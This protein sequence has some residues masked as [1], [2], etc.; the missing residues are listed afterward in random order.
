MEKNSINQNPIK[1]ALYV[2]RNSIRNIRN[3]N[4]AC[5]FNWSSAAKSSGSSFIETRG[6]TTEAVTVF[7]N[8]FWVYK[9]EVWSKML[10]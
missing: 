3:R 10:T 5:S 7:A 6:A 1:L 8:V 4:I 2:I 9:Q